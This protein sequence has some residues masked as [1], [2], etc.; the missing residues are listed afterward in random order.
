MA[1]R[2]APLAARIVA[3][4]LGADLHPGSVVVDV[5]GGEHR[6]DH[7]RDYPGDY[8]GDTARRAYDA[9]ETWRATVGD[10]EH[11]HCLTDKES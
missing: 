6:I 8:K 2:T 11:F 7:F 4:V 5:K 3:D 10:H 1:A 9:G